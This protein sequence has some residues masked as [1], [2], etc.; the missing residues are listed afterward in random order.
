L[1][2]HG[3][4]KGSGTFLAGRTS[5]TE[6]S[7]VEKAPDPFSPGA[8]RSG[9]AQLD[10]AANRR[11]NKGF[12]GTAMRIV[13]ATSLDAAAYAQQIV[14]AARAL[15]EGALV[16]FPTE[17]VYGVAAHAALP[18]AVARLRAAKGLTEV[19]RPFTVHLGRRADA[20][21]YLAAPSPIVRRLAR[22]GWPGPLTL[23]CEVAEPRETEVAAGWSDDQVAQVFHNGLVGLRCPDHAGARHLLSEAGVPVVASSAN[24][25]GQPPPRD[26]QEALDALPGAVEYVLDEGPARHGFASTVV[27]VRGNGLTIA[28]AGVLEERTIRNWARC[29]ILFVC[30]G[31]SCRSPLAEYLFRRGLAEKLQRAPAELAEDG[32]SVTSAGTSAFHGSPASDGTLAELDRRGIDARPHRSQP[33]TVELVQRADRIYV[34]TI[35]HRDAVLDLVPAAAGKVAWLDPGGDVTDPLLGGAVE[36]ERCATQI[37]QAVQKRLE[38]FLNEDLDW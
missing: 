12:A 27:E 8:R 38:E 34:M 7:G 16:I 22:R 29:E 13:H 25:V 19:A 11:D 33:L 15:R 31:N 4:E 9:G 10:G 1:E 6:N 17:T 36:Y 35:A 37:E 20:R 32:Y 14:D 2:S 26:A 24:R 18:A 28:R 5:R 23:V 30:T 21:R 3:R